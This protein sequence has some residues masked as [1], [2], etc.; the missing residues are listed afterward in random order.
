MSSKPIIQDFMLLEDLG[1]LRKHKGDA[2]TPLFRQFNL[3]YGFN[4]SGKT[5]LSRVFASLEMG[6]VHPEFSEVGDFQITVSSGPKITKTSRLDSLG[7]RIL[8]F[9]VDFIEKNLYWKEKAEPTQFSTS[10]KIRGIW[11]KDWKRPSRTCMS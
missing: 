11:F 7:N 8:V 3:I 10:V 9:N 5:T 1:I 2:T 4:G 6:K